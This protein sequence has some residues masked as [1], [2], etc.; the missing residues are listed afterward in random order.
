MLLDVALFPTSQV[1]LAEFQ[2]GRIQVCD[3]GGGKG[4]MDVKRTKGD[5]ES[6]GKRCRQVVLLCG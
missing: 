1:L 3:G 2:A 5:P 6:E 4:E